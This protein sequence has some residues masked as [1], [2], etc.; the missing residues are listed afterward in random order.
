MGKR[1][2][3]TGLTGQDGSYWQHNA[4]HER[5]LLPPRELHQLHFPNDRFHRCVQKL[6]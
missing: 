3:V 6:P 5:I 2:L 4:F 1:A